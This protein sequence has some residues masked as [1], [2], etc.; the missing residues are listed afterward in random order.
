MA[1]SAAEW[2]FSVVEVGQQQQTLQV[3]D[4]LPFAGITSQ[5]GY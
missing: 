1:C 4:H 3:T 2:W 5:A